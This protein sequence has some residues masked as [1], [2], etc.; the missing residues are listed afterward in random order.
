MYIILV[1]MNKKQSSRKE[2]S[3]ASKVL[4]SAKSSKIAKSLAGSV[5][6]QA[7]GNKKKR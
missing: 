1:V 6:A 2:A 3:K 4:Q 5:L 7:R